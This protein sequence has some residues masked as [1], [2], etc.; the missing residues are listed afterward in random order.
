MSIFIALAAFV[1][2]FGSLDE[3]LFRIAVPTLLL[4]TCACMARCSARD[5]D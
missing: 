2:L 1:H 4:V 3:F 5:H